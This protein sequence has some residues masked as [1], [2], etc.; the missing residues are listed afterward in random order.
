MMIAAMIYAS[1][2]EPPMSEKTTQRIL[3]SVGSVLMYSAIQPQTPQIILSV[4]DLVNFLFIFS[5]P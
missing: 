2:P 4:D 1:N 5:P 3:M